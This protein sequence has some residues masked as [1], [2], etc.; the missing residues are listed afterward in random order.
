MGLVIAT[1]GAVHRDGS[2]DMLCS[3]HIVVYYVVV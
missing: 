1:L 3:M 2:Y